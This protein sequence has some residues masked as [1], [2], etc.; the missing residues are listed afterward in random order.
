[1]HTY[2]IGIDIGATNTVIGLVRN[3]GQ[4][5]GKETLP[6][7]IYTETKS[8]IHD[9]VEAIRKVMKDCKVE[10]IERVGIG[11]PNSSYET[12]CIEE[13]TVNLRI[14]ERIPICKMITEELGVPAALDND[15]NAAALG[16]LVYG[17][18]KG[19]SNFIVYTLGTG[20][21]SGIVI[22][23]KV[24]RGHR[25]FA[26]ELGHVIVDPHGRKCG[27]GRVGCLE[28]YAAAASICR[29]YL[30]AHAEMTGSEPT[31]E[32]KN[33]TCKHVGEL[34]AQGDKA[35][36]AAYDKAAYWLGFALANAVAFSEPEGIFLFGGPTQVGDILMKPLKKYFEEQLLFLYKG[37]VLV[38]LS[39]L[40]SNDAAILGAAALQ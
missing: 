4:I 24:L 25:G 35:A 13:N 17:G 21:G 6:T 8:Y 36:I 14:K 20:V 27:C 28:T 11:S 33:I 34:A 18:A 5:V 26:G 3:D 9:I 22:D 37:K 30:E 39:H 40:P 2:A 12:G 15:A 7:Q 38:E 19:M 23:G 31:E 32:Q 1:M 10:A 16:E 29:N